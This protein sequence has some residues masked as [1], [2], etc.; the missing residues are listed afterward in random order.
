MVAELLGD[1]GPHLHQLKQLQMVTM[2]LLQQQACL[3]VKQL[4]AQG[5]GG[6]GVTIVVL[7]LAAGEALAGG[8]GRLY[9]AEVGAEAEAGLTLLLQLLLKRLGSRLL[10]PVQAQPR[11]HSKRRSRRW[12]P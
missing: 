10:Q 2:R 8:L 12:R 5:G 4:G 11:R 3:A 7:L 1:T 9:Q 6:G